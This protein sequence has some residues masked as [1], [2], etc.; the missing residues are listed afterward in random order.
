MKLFPV[1]AILAAVFSLTPSAS[2]V[3]TNLGVGIRMGAPTGLSIKYKLSKENALSF[4]LGWGGGYWGDYDQYYDNRCYDNNFYRNNGGYCRDQ[5]YG[6]YDRYGRYGNRDFLFTGDYL[7][8]NYKAIKASIPIPVYYGLGAQYLYVR[9][10]D[11]YIGVRGTFGAA[12]EPRS[13]PFDFFFELSP[14][15]WLYP[16]PDFDLQAGLGARFWF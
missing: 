2:A 1:A 4:G 6:Y 15:L 5:H 11:S 10:I 7:F 14:A 3:T 12:L 13:I 9:D 16:E 8:H